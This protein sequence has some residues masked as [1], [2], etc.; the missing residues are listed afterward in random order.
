LQ[1]RWD[2]YEPRLLLSS[3]KSAPMARIE[4]RRSFDGISADFL[5]QRLMWKI[6]VFCRKGKIKSERKKGEG[7]KYKRKGRGER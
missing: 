4:G 2:F 6:K 5:D 1:E 7:R 3:I